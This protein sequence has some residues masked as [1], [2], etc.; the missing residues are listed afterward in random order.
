MQVGKI[1]KR[2]S[3]IGQE[4]MSDAGKFGI[5]FTTPIAY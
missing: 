5:E 2:F 3:R 4:M 1:T